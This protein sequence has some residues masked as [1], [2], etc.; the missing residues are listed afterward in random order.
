MSV[1]KVLFVLPRMW[2]GGVERV[3]L[4]LASEFQQR[5]IKCFLVLRS[6][7]GELLSKA[8]EV[9]PDVTIIG[10]RGLHRFVPELASLMRT[11]RPTHIITAFADVGL[12]TWLARLRAGVSARLIHGVHNTHAP[13]SRRP[14]TIGRARYW[15]DDL[16]AQFLYPRA[17]ALV[18]VS[19][20]IEAEV[21]ARWPKAGRHTYTIY[22]PVASAA[23]ME[24]AVSR[25]RRHAAPLSG[26]WVIVGMGRLTRQ[27]GFDVL[28]DAAS[29]LP[30]IPDWKID[31]YGDGPERGALQRR[32]DSLGLRNRI[33]LQGY[34]DQPHEVLR[35][36]DIFVLPSRYEGFALVVAEAMVHGV[37][38]L[39]AD[40]PHGPRE[41]LNA[42]EFGQLVPAD[43]AEAFASALISAMN[44]EVW[45]P[46][47]K[48]QEKAANFSTE[49]SITRWLALLRKQDL[50]RS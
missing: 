6:D 16:V 14:G 45:S 23:F 5:G 33:T 11:C 44:R 43:N 41:L 4:Q 25:S 28:V 40:C 24:E 17:D 47:E 22:N 46:P 21:R 12:L 34:T 38:I 50:C 9:F 37:Q 42:G 19:K 10:V 36:A 2:S 15:I 18:C 3:I 49:V 27:K 29:M 48:L 8:Q 31:I 32:I 20:G 30:K 1:T 7:E 39:A 13:A 35:E 26:C